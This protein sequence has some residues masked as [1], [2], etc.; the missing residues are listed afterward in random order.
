M[1]T[2]AWHGE[3][4]VLSVTYVLRWFFL[5]AFTEAFLVKDRNVA[6]AV[7]KTVCN[8]EPPEASF[9]LNA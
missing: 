4:N 2:N 6:F 7:D 1:E 3:E 5:W 9:I 8:K